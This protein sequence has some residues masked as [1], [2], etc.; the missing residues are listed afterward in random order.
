MTVE[1]GFHS[2]SYTLLIQ[3]NTTVS[4]Q[5]ATSWFSQELNCRLCI[6]C[7]FTLFLLVL[8]MFFLITNNNATWNEWSDRTNVHFPSE[9]KYKTRQFQTG[10]SLYSYFN[11]KKRIK[12]HD[13]YWFKAKLLVILMG[14]NLPYLRG[15]HSQRLVSTQRR[16]TRQT[17]FRLIVSLQFSLFK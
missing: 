6:E 5:P 17:T 10:F 4:S 3:E 16:N 2:P 1:N 15:L 12:G 11:F 13:Q 14:Q 7:L 9:H 8:N